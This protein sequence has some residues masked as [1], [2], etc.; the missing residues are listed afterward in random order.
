[1]LSRPRSSAA[2]ALVLASSL[3]S[4]A[5]CDLD[6]DAQLEPAPVEVQTFHDG[7]AEDTEGGAFRVT[8][9]ARDG[10]ELGDNE[11]IVHVGF[12]ESSD[13][14]DPGR[15]IPGADLRL[16]AWMPY[17]DGASE[18]LVGT[19]VGEGRYQIEGLVLDRPGIW[20]LDFAVAVGETLDERVSFAFVI[21]PSPAEAPKSGEG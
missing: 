5:G 3:A 21:E 11:L 20:Q 19:H 13:S 2:L 4:L 10:L 18:T 1:M 12:H 16:D 7:I 14:S 17:A 8:L 9:H 6:G 15:G